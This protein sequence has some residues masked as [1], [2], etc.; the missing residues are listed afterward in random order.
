[1][2][3][4]LSFFIDEK[5]HEHKYK[6]STGRWF[7]N[8]FHW[9]LYNFSFWKQKMKTDSKVSLSIYFHFNIIS[10]LSFHA[11][12]QFVCFFSFFLLFR[13]Y[14]HL[15]DNI[16]PRQVA[17][18]TFLL[19]YLMHSYICRYSRLYFYFCTKNVKSAHIKTQIKWL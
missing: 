3:I 18:I 1:M 12:M 19:G 13:C 11:W 14:L 5:K 8:L 17:S 4:F 9:K 15:F 7:L 6:I 10:I 2:H 16:Y